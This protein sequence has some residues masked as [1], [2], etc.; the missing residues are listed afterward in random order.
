LLE[1]KSNYI[2]EYIA[3]IDP[4]IANVSPDPDL[5]RA[6]SKSYT[7]NRLFGAFKKHKT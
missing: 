1:C 5:N 3:T 4:G 2:L 7:F 6:H